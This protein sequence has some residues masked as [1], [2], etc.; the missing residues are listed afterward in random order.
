MASTTT[1][2]AGALFP[3]VRRPARNTKWELP[4]GGSLHQLSFGR[5]T[6]QLTFRRNSASSPRRPFDPALGMSAWV[7]SGHS[8]YTTFLWMRVALIRQRLLHSWRG[9][10]D[11]LPTVRFS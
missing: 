2:R 7:R 8:G 3:P 5:R 10:I 1:N 9:F 4:F 11:S 6:K